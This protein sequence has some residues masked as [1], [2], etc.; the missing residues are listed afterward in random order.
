MM[1]GTYNVKLVCKLLRSIFTRPC[2]LR[3]IL[4]PNELYY[5]LILGIT[6][7][8]QKEGKI[9]LDQ[10]RKYFKEVHT[11]GCFFEHILLS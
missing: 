11:R 1:H 4:N 10:N 6:M 3:S 7:K 8:L 9:L 2:L 5:S